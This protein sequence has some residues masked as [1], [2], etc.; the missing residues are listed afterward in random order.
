MVERS[1]RDKNIKQYLP[2]LI[3]LIAVYAVYS[4]YSGG[5]GA[6]SSSG[7]SPSLESTSTTKPAAPPSSDGKE[8]GKNRQVLV[9]VEPLNLRSAPTKSANNVIASLTKASQLTLQEQANG[10]LKVSLPDGRSGYVAYD[11]RYVRI[12]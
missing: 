3:L 1:S 7:D 9:L 6:I 11:T 10:W 5:S 8:A 2:W 12:K 4:A